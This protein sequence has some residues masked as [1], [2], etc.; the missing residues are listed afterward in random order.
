MSLDLISSPEVRALLGGI[1]VK[2]LQRYR[3]KRWIDGVHYFKPVQRCLYN[4]PLIQDWM[5]N[6]A[7]DPAAHQDAI[8]AWIRSQQ[9][10]NGR[11]A[12]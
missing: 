9:G 12:S 5:R 4:R 1:S 11:K 2:T 3:D 7:H 10:G 8:E 6:A